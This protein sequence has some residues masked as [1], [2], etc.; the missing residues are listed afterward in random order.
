[1]ALFNDIKIR[2]LDQEGFY[3]G[4]N[5]NHQGINIEFIL[6]QIDPW[7][8][9]LSGYKWSI[10][11]FN[12]SFSLPLGAN[13]LAGDRVNWIFKQL[14]KT[15]PNYK[16]NHSIAIFIHEKSLELIDNLGK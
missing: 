11:V 14:E 3:K 4:K 5:Y 2:K 12:S 10:V 15:Y 6:Q 1:M 13:I 8:N 9:D 16:D 7:K